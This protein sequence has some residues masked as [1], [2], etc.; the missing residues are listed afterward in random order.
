MLRP[1]PVLRRQT[2]RMRHRNNAQFHWFWT[3]ILN[4]RV[5]R[6]S[7]PQDATLKR[8]SMLRNAA[9][10]ILRRARSDFR[11]AKMRL[12]IRCFSFAAVNLREWHRRCVFSAVRS[13]RQVRPALHWLIGHSEFYSECFFYGRRGSAKIG[14]GSTRS[15]R[16]SRSR[17]SIRPRDKYAR[18]FRDLLLSMSPV[19]MRNF[20]RYAV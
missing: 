9:V 8:W 11:D 12:Y 4:H 19:I 18:P 13:R 1:E 2:S 16:M 14:I 5:A 7:L 6:N 17:D 10:G 15:K 3:R 20:R